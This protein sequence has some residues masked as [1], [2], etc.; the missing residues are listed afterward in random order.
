M[1]IVDLTAPNRVVRRYSAPLSDSLDHVTGRIVTV[2]DVTA[3]W[4]AR[5]RLTQ[6]QKMES[7]TR[8]AGGVAH[9]FNNLIGAILGF[10]SL[11]AERTP[12]SDPQRE[13]IEG[14]LRHAERATRLT[15]ALLAFSRN[16]RFERIPVNLNRVVDESYALLRAALDPGV[17]IEIDL[18]PDVPPVMGDAVLLQQLVVHLVQEAGL[19]L[20]PGAVLEIA[21]RLEAEG[22][23]TSAGGAGGT[24]GR[25]VLTVGV[26]AG[27]PGAESA[28]ESAGADATSD[29]DEAV[30]LS[31][32]EDI[33]R[34]HGGWLR[35]GSAA[36]PARFRVGLP[37]RPA[38]QALL[39]APDEAMAKGDERILMVD[40]EPG[41]LSV[42]K[43]GLARLPGDHRAERRAGAGDPALARR[44]DRPRPPRPQHART[45]GRARP[46]GDP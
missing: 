20:G 15:Q 32:I 39:L 21:T 2:E 26:R 19:R 28:G 34:V 46:A 18:A 37:V 1:E 35:R 27:S 44:R 10:A 5:R 12:A 41:L 11:L 23:E 42:V 16:A 43:V 7:L 6:A 25:V 13:P 30:A 45:L 3:S 17:A 9:D 31:V 29:I 8:L 24:G 40:D 22:A 38:E 4:F 33:A 14:I 36:A